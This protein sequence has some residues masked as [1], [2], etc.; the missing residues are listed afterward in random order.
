[1]SNEYRKEVNMLT[2]ESWWTFWKVLLFIVPILLILSIL[3][4]VLGL[5]SRPAQIIDR[6]TQP[7]RII[8]NY[9]W[10]EET[11]ND[12]GALDS[13]ISNAQLQVDSFSDGLGSRDTWSRDDRIE[14]NRLN[15]I[16]LGLRNQRDSVVAQYNAR[17]NQITRNLFK[18][19]SLP[20]QLKVVGDSTMEVWVK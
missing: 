10:F 20:Y 6:V 3:I 9:E 2:K 1:M 11:Y 12:T 4:W 5:L 14:F 15:A 7:D 19:S 16:V 8:Q 13:Q 18:G 17:S